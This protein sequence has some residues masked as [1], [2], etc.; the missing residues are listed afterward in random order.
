MT[1]IGK[2]NFQ[3]IG[4]GRH[5]VFSPLAKNAG[6]FSRDRVSQFFMKGP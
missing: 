2:F 1:T 3:K 6:I 5:F 4:V